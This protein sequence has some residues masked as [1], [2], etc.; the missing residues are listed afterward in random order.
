LRC[1]KQNE[2]IICEDCKTI[3]YPWDMELYFSE[4]EL[5]SGLMYIDYLAIEKQI[6]KEPIIID[7]RFAICNYQ[8]AQF[9]EQ[10]PALC[11]CCGAELSDLLDDGSYKHMTSKKVCNCGQKLKWD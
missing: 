9:N 10:S 1:D 5:P 3:H 2:T 6:P 8:A 11:P 7:N 4:L